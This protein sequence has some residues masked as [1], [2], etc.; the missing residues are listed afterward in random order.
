M[1]LL[2]Y[3]HNFDSFDPTQLAGQDPVE[4]RRSRDRHFVPGRAQLRLVGG[5]KSD[6]ITVRRGSKAATRAGLTDGRLLATLLAVRRSLQQYS[7]FLEQWRQ[8]MCAA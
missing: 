1:R 2:L 6:A 3:E 7:T 8:A 4:F 5:W